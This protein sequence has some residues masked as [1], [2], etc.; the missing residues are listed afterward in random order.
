MVVYLCRGQFVAASR[1]SQ[2]KQLISELYLIWLLLWLWVIISDRAVCKAHVVFSLVFVD[3]VDAETGGSVAH[4]ML[5][6]L[7][8]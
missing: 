3:G 1:G 2:R 8:L 6:L 4:L 7:N 5:R